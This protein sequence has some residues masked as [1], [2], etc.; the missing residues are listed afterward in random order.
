[1]SPTKLQI[2]AAYWQM[3]FVVPI[4]VCLLALSTQVRATDLNDRASI[5][6]AFDS[7]NSIVRRNALYAA[8]HH[9]GLWVGNL[10]KTALADKSPVVVEVAVQQIG[11]LKLG[12]LTSQL[13]TQYH[14]AEV[15]Y[16]GYAER[17]R[18]AIIPALGK[19][20]GPEATAFLVD[21]LQND[22]G[23]YMGG[24][25][26]S[27]IQEL[28]DKSLISNV[29]QYA[30]KMNG[31]VVKAKAQNYDPLAYSMQL[32]YIEIAKKVEL[33]LLEKGGDNE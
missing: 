3:L 18:Y 25:I 15:L 7:E 20:G 33:A 24:F 16:K 21:L 28:G 8:A 13:I 14:Q 29:Q 22:K 30:E 4:V 23:T 26:L 5:E 12:S 19:L 2:R 32:Q 17:V 11:N 6:S 1:M 31:V 9:Q 10:F 27:A